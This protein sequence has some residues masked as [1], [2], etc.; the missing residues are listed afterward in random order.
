[1]HCRAELIHTD[2]DSFA[3]NPKSSF[4]RNM[5]GVVL[6][7]ALHLV[8][9]QS[10][11][12][13]GEIKGMNHRMAQKSEEEKLSIQETHVHSLSIQKATPVCS[14]VVCVKS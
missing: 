2:A 10:T 12:I 8:Q 4:R 14:I 7:N 1:M 9:I 6:T 11:G 3:S 13:L 5:D